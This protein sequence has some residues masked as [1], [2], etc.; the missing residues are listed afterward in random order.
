MFFSLQLLLQPLLGWQ[1]ANSGRFSGLD[2]HTLKGGWVDSLGATR[3][4]VDGGLLLVRC[5]DWY[6]DLPPLFDSLNASVATC[7]VLGKGV[8]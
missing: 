4:V 8:S 5:S 2:W 1:L 6:S 3:F 7:W